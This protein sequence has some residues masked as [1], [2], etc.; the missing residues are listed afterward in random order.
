VLGRLLTGSGVIDYA[1]L[2]KLFFLLSV[3][4]SDLAG[5]LVENMGI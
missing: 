3:I 5:G 2:T 4:S 1:C